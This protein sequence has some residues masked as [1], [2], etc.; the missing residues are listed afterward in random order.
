MTNLQIALLSISI[1]AI[2]ILII[3]LIYIIFLVRRANIVFKKVDY[4]IEDITYKAESLNVAVDAINKIANY[5][6]TLDLSTALRNRYSTQ[7]RMNVRWTDGGNFSRD[8]LSRINPCLS[9][10]PS[11]VR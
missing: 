11:I 9:I 4:L 1:A 6:L 10:L 2:A 8:A 5:T 7:D 3:L